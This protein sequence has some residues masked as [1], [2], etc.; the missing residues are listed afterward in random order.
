M[1]PPWEAELSVSVQL[2]S[3]GEQDW[4]YMPPPYKEEPLAPPRPPRMT[5]ESRSAEEFNASEEG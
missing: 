1:P 2:V 4:L 3:A 5:T